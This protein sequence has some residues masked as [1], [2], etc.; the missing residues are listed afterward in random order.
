MEYIPFISINDISSGHYGCFDDEIPQRLFD[1][2][3]DA[4][5]A[6]LNIPTLPDARPGPVKGGLVRFFPFSHFSNDRD[7]DALQE[8]T[9]LKDPEEY[10][11]R[12]NAFANKTMSCAWDIDR[13]IDVAAEGLSL[14]YTDLDKNNFRVSLDDPLGDVLV[15][16]FEHASW[17]PCCFSR[18]CCRADETSRI[19]ASFWPFSFAVDRFGVIS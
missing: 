15:M 10:V 11:G 8:Y 3:A 6:F 17:L 13:P 18:I 19:S 2:V 5:A 16:N 1:R 14:C 12:A 7:C 4:L 9:R